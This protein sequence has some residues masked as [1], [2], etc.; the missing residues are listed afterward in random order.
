MSS[1][2]SSSSNPVRLRS[3]CSRLRSPR[4][5]LSFSSSHSPEIL[6]NAMFSAFSSVLLRLTVTHSTSSYPRSCRTKKRWWPPIMV[7]S[8][9]TIMGSTYPNFL[10]LFFSFSYSGIPGSSFTR[11]LYFA[12][13]SLLSFNFFVVI[14]LLEV[15]KYLEIF[16]QKIDIFWAR[17][18]AALSLPLVVPTNLSQILQQKRPPLGEAFYFSSDT[19]RRAYEEN[20]I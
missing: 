14:L 9:F 6:F 8:A 2:S 10:I 18:G 12:G 4:S 7:P 15:M 1:V 19:G 20:I 11:G 3:N 5:A 16:Y 17:G 13:F